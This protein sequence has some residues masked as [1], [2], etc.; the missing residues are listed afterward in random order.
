MSEHEIIELNEMIESDQMATVES[1]PW[2]P[3]HTMPGTMTYKDLIKGEWYK[4]WKA[5]NADKLARIQ[6]TEF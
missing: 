1:D 5:S 2:K 6:V 3:W 4:I